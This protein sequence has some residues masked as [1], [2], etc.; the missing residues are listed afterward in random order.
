FLKYHV[1][2]GAYY[3]NDLKDGQFIPSLIDGQYIQVGIRVDGCR[4][5]LVE[6]NVSPLY[7]ADIPASNGVIHVV[8][9]ILKPADRDWCENVILPR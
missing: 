3:S 9:W 4:R 1:A 7:R 6:A 8:D 5:R 2:H